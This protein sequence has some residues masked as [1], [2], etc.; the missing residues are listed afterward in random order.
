MSTHTKQPYDPR[1]GDEDPDN[2]DPTPSR[3]NSNDYEKPPGPA[4]PSPDAKT[5]AFALPS[6]LQ[7][8]PANLSWPKLKPVIRNAISAWACLILLIVNSSLRT[9]GQ[10]GFLIMI[11]SMISPPT[12]PFAATT[13]RELFIVL[14]ATVAWAW[15]S[16]GIYLA[17]LARSN[18]VPNARP[19]DIF[20]GSYLEAGPTVILAVFLFTGATFFLYIK[21]RFGPGPF[22]IPSILACICLDIGITTAVLFPYANYRAGQA[23]VLPLAFH[24]AVAI[25]SSVLIFP[26][27]ITTQH[28]ARVCGVLSPLR[29]ALNAQLALLKIPTSSPDFTP[30]G[31]RGAAG[32][33]EAALAPLAA[34]ARLLKRDVS[35]GRFS[36]QDIDS[37][38]GDVQRLVL[39]SN[40]MNTYY[41]LIDPTRERFPVTPAPS[42]PGTPG[43]GSPAISRPPSPA[44]GGKDSPSAN[45]P[46]AGSPSATLTPTTLSHADFSKTSSRTIAARSARRRHPHFEVDDSPAPSIH[47]SHRHSHTQFLHGLHVPLTTHHHREH[48]VGVFESQRYLDLETQHFAHPNGAQFIQR[49]NELLSES[50]EDLLTSCGGAVGVF[51]QWL[52]SGLND[53]WVFWKGGKKRE[54]LQRARL[55]KLYAAT[56]DVTRVLSSFRKDK[57]LLVLEPYRSA[58]DPKHVGSMTGE[59]VPPHRYLFHCYVYQY[60]LMQFSLVLLKTLESATKLEKD[61]VRTRLWLPAMPLSNYQQWSI[62]DHSGG[63][64]D[65]ENPDIVQGMDTMDLGLALRRDPDALPP[66]NRFEM[67]MNFFYM[68]V[69]GLF[70]GNALFAVKAGFLTVLLSCPYFFKSS[71]AFAYRERGSWA[72]FM[73][74]LTI[75]RFRGDTTFGL[76]SRVISTFTGA[77]VGVTV[78]YIS[79]GSGTGNAYGLAATCA[80]CF[81]FFFYGRLY[82][83]GPVLTNVIFFVTVAL[84]FGFSWQ[85]T[86]YQIGPFAHYGIDLAWRR[87]L[88][89]TIGVTAAFLFSFLPPSTTLRGYQRNTFATTAAEVGTVYCS[90]VSYANARYTENAQDVLQSLIAIR[91]KLKR[92]IVLRTNIVYEFSLRGRYPAARYQKILEIQLEIAYL[93]SHLMSV[94]EHL[95]PA[96]SRAFLRRTRLIDSDFQGDVLAVISMISTSLRTGG[97]LPQITP[98]PLF[99]RFIMY[100]HGLN[101]IRNEA[102]DDYGLPRTMTIDTLEDEQYLCFCVGVSTVFGFVTRLDRL[103]MATKELVGEQYHIHGV[104]YV[105]KTS[106]VEMTSRTNSLRPTSE[107]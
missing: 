42:R 4:P 84:I 89:V 71:A 98:C 21:G 91:L 23:V 44:R 9:M 92:S 10:A 69:Q 97:P 2:E 68:A 40:G 100:Q 14:F 54:Q 24:A 62:W 7:W 60:H 6:N 67:L 16:L 18:T 101:V 26:S 11:V 50:C 65:D 27:S 94:I 55:D 90:I 78:W 59:G 17:S 43:N 36:G 61:R 12:D 53:K 73:G 104:G 75:S 93:L 103:M 107:V 80:V 37:L 34:S 105:A 85:N 106:G 32:K 48:V 13:E 96:W 102:D 45:S 38:R 99:D 49:A 81:P 86:H 72:I 15:S 39:R 63:L 83:P 8:I 19:A 95:E 56:D 77:L 58:F 20:A 47:H 64:D 30:A 79:T 66:G 5:P 31:V 70:H 52:E 46:S 22:F 35:W 76:V 57:R 29:S 3:R 74:Q 25:T 41:G 87:F 1:I 82:W 88:L 51:E 28:V 33:A